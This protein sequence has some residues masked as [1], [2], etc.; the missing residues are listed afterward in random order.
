MLNPIKPHTCPH[1]HKVVKAPMTLQCAPGHT[2]MDMTGNWIYHCEHCGRRV[3]EPVASGEVH[4]IFADDTASDEYFMDMFD[5]NRAVAHLAFPSVSDFLNW[6]LRASEDPPAMWYHVIYQNQQICAGAIDPYDYEG[7]MN[8]FDLQP[9]TVKIEL[10]VDRFMAYVNK[11]DAQ[12]CEQL[13]RTPKIYA[14]SDLVPAKLGLYKRTA[15]RDME[16]WEDHIEPILTDFDSELF[17]VSGDP[18]NLVVT[19]QPKETNDPEIREQQRDYF[20]PTESE[21]LSTLDDYIQFQSTLPMW[22]AT[23]E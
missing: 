16:L 6:F 19:M 7:Y 20:D 14:L 13:G 15:E 18:E 23:K 11:E 8:A 22:R 3:L 9:D 5:G 4:V 17:C 21:L 12:R 10:N 2:I 1:C